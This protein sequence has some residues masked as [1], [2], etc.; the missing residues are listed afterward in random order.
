MAKPRSL[1]D[2]LE[3]VWRLRD[4]SPSAEG[5]ALLRSTLKDR[6]SFLVAEAAAIIGTQALTELGDDLAAAFDRFMLDPEETDKGCR[7]LIAITDTLNRLDY[8][9][10][11]VFLRGVRHV[12]KIWCTPPEDHAAPLRAHAAMGLAR[13]EYPGVIYLLADLLLDEEAAARAGAAQA[14]A[15]TGKNSVIPLLRFK[16][17]LGD[18]DSAVI[19]DCFAG[20]IALDPDESI[21]FVAENLNGHRVEVQQEAAL[22]LGESRNPA[23]LEHLRKRWT[24]GSHDAIQEALLLAVAMLRVPAAIDFL[25]EIL[26]GGDRSAAPAALAALAIHR[27]NPDVRKR[28]AAAIEGK[29]PTLTSL[30]EKKFRT[31]D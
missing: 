3:Q 17:R 31:A 29:G 16:V 24:E 2:K 18:R 26:A 9:Q 12:Q 13:I 19:G 30:F 11:E 10:P 21:P 8:Q 6:S 22:A 5:T 7:A 14:L 20:L 4:Q 23:A 27:H 25:L 28:T 15:A 1:N